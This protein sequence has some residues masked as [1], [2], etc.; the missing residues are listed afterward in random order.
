[1]ASAVDKEQIEMLSQLW[2]DYG[3]GILIAVIIGLGVG[4]GWKYWYQH[5]N[6]YRAQSSVA[7]QQFYSA[8]VM[9]NDKAAATYLTNLKTK[10]KDS[11]YAS[12]GALLNARVNAEEG[13]AKEAL[14]QLQ[15][16]IDNSKMASFREMARIR[17]A[18]ILLSIKQY[19]EASNILQVVDDKSY[20]PMLDNVKG[21]IYAAQGEKE[22]SEQAYQA[23][24]TGFESMG[25][26]NP[27]L[28]MK[29]SGGADN[30]SVGSN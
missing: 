29:L 9:R 5:K 4:L 24:K 16:V 8:T 25:L 28:D 19:S 21:D 13:N 23:A 22:K 17:S 2:K 10:F 7:Y 30:M 3:R 26:N 18:Q 1:M 12:M 15:W 14:T 6:V 27:I 11:P 20:Q